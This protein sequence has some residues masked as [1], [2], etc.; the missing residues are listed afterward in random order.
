MLITDV[1]NYYKIDIP[2]DKNFII[3]INY[4]DS[5]FTMVNVEYNNLSQY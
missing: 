2:N 1:N 4:E 3:L 5:K